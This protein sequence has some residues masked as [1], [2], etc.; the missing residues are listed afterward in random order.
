M[1]FKQEW[2]DFDRKD[3]LLVTSTKDLTPDQHR[4]L[5]HLRRVTAARAASEQAERDAL[6]D[7]ML[8][9]V[10]RAARAARSAESG[11][12]PQAP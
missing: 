6:H 2:H 5:I 4:K 11:Q 8:A 3:A 9:S 10:K 1:W 12:T 7:G